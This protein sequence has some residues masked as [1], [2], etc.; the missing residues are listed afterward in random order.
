KVDG[1]VKDQRFFEREMARA[2][3]EGRRVM[4]DDGVACIVF[5]HKTTE[6]WE[7]LLS[8]MR[9]AGWTI[10]ASWPITTEMGSRMRAMD[11]DALAGSVHLVCR[12]RDPNAGVGDWSEVKAAMEK[13]IR[14]WLPT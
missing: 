13:R 4:R 6:G 14:E 11:F 5:A 7:A 9:R 12:P 3:S 2:F 10:T 8:G 1:G